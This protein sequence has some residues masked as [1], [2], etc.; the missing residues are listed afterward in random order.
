MSILGDHVSEYLEELCVCVGLDASVRSVRWDDV[1]K[2]MPLPI[3]AAALALRFAD[4]RRGGAQPEMLVRTLKFQ[5]LGCGGGDVVVTGIAPLGSRERGIVF[6][7]ATEMNSREE[8]LQDSSSGTTA[9]LFQELDLPVFSDAV[10]RHCVVCGANTMADEN[11]VD[12][13]HECCVFWARSCAQF[14]K[15]QPDDA[16]GGDEFGWDLLAASNGDD[17]EM[18]DVGRVCELGVVGGTL[19]Q[20]DKETTRIEGDKIVLVCVYDHVLDM[21]VFVSVVPP[22]ALL[23]A[24]F[25]I[26]DVVAN[27]LVPHMRAVS[28]P[29]PFTRE[30]VGDMCAVGGLSIDMFALARV[31]AHYQPLFGTQGAFAQRAVA[32]L[33]AFGEAVACAGGVLGGAQPVRL[34]YDDVS[35]CDYVAH[36]NPYADDW[37]CTG[38]TTGVSH[39]VHSLRLSALPVATPLPRDPTWRELLKELLCMKYGRGDDGLTPHVCYAFQDARPGAV[40]APFGMALSSQ[41]R[42]TEFVPGGLSMLVQHARENPGLERMFMGLLAVVSR[43]FAF[44]RIRFFLQTMRIPKDH[45]KY[46]RVDECVKYDIR[47]LVHLLGLNWPLESRPA[48]PSTP[49]AMAVVRFSCADTF[50]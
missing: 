26:A 19:N 25:A 43:R 18:Q 42:M 47:F 40:S 7:A 8:Y 5:P 15:A 23:L 21:A 44:A 22:R 27:V 9:L 29:S 34:P 3:Q 33:V 12:K 39:F 20:D 14:A 37:L 2:T 16:M 24:M 10:N 6:A 4:A 36:T 30:I 28:F 1:R 38:Q 48:A 45:F 32:F 49:A 41:M 11:G 50:V 31:A 46:A 13:G 17:M 35:V